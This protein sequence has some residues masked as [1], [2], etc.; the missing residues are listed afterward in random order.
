[1]SQ[2]QQTV[3][4]IAAS[5]PDGCAGIAA[6]LRTFYALGIH[7]A[8]CLTAATVQNTKTYSS[9]HAIPPA[10]ISA[11]LDAVFSD[12]QIDAVK[13]GLVVGEEQVKAIANAL[14]KWKAKNIVLDPVMSAQPGGKG[15]IDKK[16]AK[17]IAAYLVPLCT[18]ITPN[19][20]EAFALTGKKDATQAASALQQMGAANVVVKGLKKGKEIA[21]FALL[22]SKQITLTKKLAA[23]STHGGGCTFS[24]ALA[25]NLA[26]GRSPLHSLAAAENF[27]SSS[28]ANAWK[29]GKGIAAVEP[30]GSA[31]KKAVLSE[32]ADAV[33]LFESDNNAAKIIPEISTNI[34]YSM[35]NTTSPQDV[36]GVVGRIRHAGGAARSIG[37]VDFGA[38]SHVARML[39]MFSKKYPAIRSAINIAYSPSILAACRK[40]GLS[41]VV[42][43]R[44]MEPKEIS[45]KEGASLGWLVEN[46]LSS[47]R[48]QPAAIYFTGS[49]G[50]EP[51]IVLFGK[52]PAEAVRLALKIAASI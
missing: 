13:I 44:M 15:I 41:V 24:S 14:R 30:L 4:T 43:D 47:S 51:S 42:A 1:M 39:L 23:T 34:T 45:A 27:I 38:S 19:Q 7:G 28:I 50:R 5:D 21:D 52:N 3:L 20:P 40:L 2:R 49:V 36:A 11:Q 17:A 26:K 25:A 18:F 8:V 9:A 37:L 35:P 48:T 12:L 6:D 29:P 32:L 10:T 16:T 46:A 31:E 33:A 22:S